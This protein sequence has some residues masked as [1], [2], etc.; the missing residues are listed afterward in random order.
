MKAHTT[1]D[2]GG[3]F[4]PVE[5]KGELEQEIARAQALAKGIKRH[6]A[7][8]EKLGWLFVSKARQFGDQAHYARVLQCAN[9]L[10]EW[11]KHRLDAKLLRAHIYH[12]EH[13]FS[14]AEK[15]ARELT[16]KRELAF[17]HG[18]LG[19][20]LFEQGKVREAARAYQSMMDLNPGAQAYARA[21]QI[22]WIQGKAGAA[23]DAMQRAIRASSVRDPEALAW[24]Y[25]QL[26]KFQ[27]HLGQNDSALE[28]LGRALDLVKNYPPALSTQAM[29]IA[30]QGNVA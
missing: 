11:P 20:A 22:F 15:L 19:D 29:I 14:A 8:Y 30:G 12:Q 16:E 7:A 3:V 27:W 23:L 9:A 6:G 1:H 5:G 13:R 10:D 18:V 24:Y 28:S 21:A 2:V 25:N 26:G 17:N 4:D